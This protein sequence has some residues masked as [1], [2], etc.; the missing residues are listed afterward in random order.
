MTITHQLGARATRAG[1]GRASIQPATSNRFRP[2]VISAEV[3]PPERGGQGKPEQGGHD[4]A[5]GQFDRT[6]ADPDGDHR[7]AERDQQDQ[8]VPFDEMAGSNRKDGLVDEVGRDPVEDAPNS[9]E[10]DANASR[11]ESGDQQEGCGD[12]VEWT[13]PGDRRHDLLLG[14]QE[15]ASVNQCHDH[16]ADA[17]CHATAAEGGGN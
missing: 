6:Q 8:P 12:E 15:E 9:K 3:E 7:L 2:F 11:S 16:I 13:K 5:G 10:K 1:T 14:T 17:E 4:S